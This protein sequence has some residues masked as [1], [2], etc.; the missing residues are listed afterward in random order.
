MTRDLLTAGINTV[1]GSAA[2]SLGDL[3]N[4]DPDGSRAA[5]IVPHL[6]RIAADP[7][8]DVRAC[9]A[10]LLHA[11]IRRD[12]R[13]AADAFAVLVQAPD[14]LLAS[15]YVSRLAV[16]LMHGDPASVGLLT[17]RMLHSLVAPV[18]RVGGQVAAPAAMEWETSDLLAKVLAGND[19]AQRQGAADVCA[20]SPEHG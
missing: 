4:H 15:P 12:R 7:S 10:H 18:R 17:E 1:R 3:L 16:A 13:A 20:A 8:L 9:V 14:H 2:E 19:T 6:S 11:A 5:L